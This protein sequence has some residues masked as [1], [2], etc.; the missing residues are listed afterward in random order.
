MENRLENYLNIFFIDLV[1]KL[2]HLSHK[3]LVK[4]NTAAQVIHKQQI[5]KDLTVTYLFIS[6]AALD[7]Y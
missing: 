2:R 6:E 7:P 4:I 3:L 5:T 1:L